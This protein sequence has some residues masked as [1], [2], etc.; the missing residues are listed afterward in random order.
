MFNANKDGFLDE[1]ELMRVLGSDGRQ[2]AHHPLDGSGG[3]PHDDALMH[4]LKMWSKSIRKTPRG[5]G[6]SGEGGGPDDGDGG[7][8][9]GGG[10]SRGGERSHGVSRA[11]EPEWEDDHRLAWDRLKG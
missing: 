3:S 7:G 2:Q 11:E 6:S 8:Q 1:A 10:G 4:E 5:A 9:G